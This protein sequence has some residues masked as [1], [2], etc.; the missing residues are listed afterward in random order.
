MREITVKVNSDIERD[1]VLKA[2]EEIGCR[3]REGQKPT[4]WHSP[5]LTYPY[6]I[7]RY[8][9]GSLAC[10]KRTLLTKEI[11][12]RRFRGFMV[13]KT[14]SKSNLKISIYSDG[15]E[16][17]D[18]G[19]N[20]EIGIAK[21][22]PEDKFSLETGAKLAIERMF[23]IHVG[24]VVRV[25]NEGKGYSTYINFFDHHNLSSEIT[26]RYAYKEYLTDGHRAK[27]IAIYPHESNGDRIAVLSATN[28]K[29]YL[30][31][32]EGLERIADLW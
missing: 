4:T 8:K 16:V 29:I 25:V 9:D 6:F 3:W 1:A 15:K 5:Y 13:K 21:C 19:E 10:G 23:G 30:V 22:N 26:A 2:Y 11:P 14:K 7:D 17:K 12:I 18:V 24:D 28:N 20:G 31:G 27:V 32:V